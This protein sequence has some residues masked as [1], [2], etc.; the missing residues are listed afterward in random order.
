TV[1]MDY[2]AL[3]YLTNAYLSALN[4]LRLLAPL[5]LAIPLR[6][7]LVDSLIKVDRAMEQYDRL[8]FG[9]RSAAFRSTLAPPIE[10]GMT[11]MGSRVEQMDRTMVLSEQR[12]MDGFVV[13]YKRAVQDYILKCF[14]EGIY[15]GLVH[16]ESLFPGPEKEEEEEEVAVVV[17]EE[18]KEKENEPLESQVESSGIDPAE[19]PTQETAAD[20][21]TQAESTSPRPESEPSAEQIQSEPE[22]TITEQAT[23][24]ERPLEAE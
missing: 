10:M 5:S 19:P 9:E 4:S 6:G 22:E 21:I 14:D 16:L 20:I 13:V 3:A 7:I 17:E 18:A 8:I 12:I 23:G 1:L 11:N 24:A 15:G 2:P